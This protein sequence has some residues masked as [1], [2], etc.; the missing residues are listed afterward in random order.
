[1]K[2]SVDHPRAHF[3]S[4]RTP[5]KI[6]IPKSLSQKSMSRRVDP[7]KLDF[8]NFVPKHEAFKIRASKIEISKQMSSNSA[9]PN[10]HSTPFRREMRL[11]LVNPPL[12]EFF[13]FSGIEHFK[14][15]SIIQ[16][17]SWH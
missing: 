10:S 17:T 8:R 1:M 11:L 6:R 4:D 9:H 15:T 5:L 2:V 12:A 16:R 13:F 7:Q 3:I 14:N